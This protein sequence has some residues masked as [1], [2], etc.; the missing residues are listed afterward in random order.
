MGRVSVTVLVVLAFG[1]SPLVYAQSR[2]VPRADTLSTRVRDSLIAAVLADTLDADV[3]T[4]ALLPLLPSF[5][6]TVTIRPTI[7]RYS[8]GNVNASEQASYASWVGRF[9]HATLRLDLTPVSYS[10]DTNTS[11]VD[12]PQVRFSGASP[13][14]GRLDVPFR[15]ADTVRVFAQS[16]SFPGA[17][18]AIDARALGAVG[19]ST[20]DLDAGALGIAARVG[21]RY[22]LTQKLGQGGVALTVRGGVEYEPKPSGTEAVSWRGTTLRGAVGV[23]RTAESGSVGTSIEFAKSHADSLGGRNLFPGGGTLNLDARALRYFGHDGTG[24][25]SLNGFYSRPVNV[26]RPDVPTRIIPVGDFFGATASAAI[27]VGRVSVVPVVSLLRESSHAS[28]IVSGRNTTLDASGQTASLSLGVSVP[29]GSVVTITPEV[30]GVFG[31]VGQTV[32]AQYPRRVRRQSFSDPIR[33]GWIS[34]ELSVSR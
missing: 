27:P 34:I 9:R 13:I 31:N 15:S 17:L 10:G 24:F 30:G 3:D 26:Q 8:V 6:Q 22:T 7:R 12:R 2:P 32:S 29:L 1:I 5:R 19:T 14:S 20:V 25:V 4:T 18:T 21:T 33:G 16:M 11:T 28:A 23:S